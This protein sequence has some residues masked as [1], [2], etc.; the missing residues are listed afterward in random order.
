MPLAPATVDRLA[1]M[2]RAGATNRAVALALGISK[3][4][5]GRYR[6]ALGL[7]PAPVERRSPIPIEQKFRDRTRPVPGTP[8]L[9]WTGRTRDGVPVITHHGA[10]VTARPIAFRIRTGRAPVGYVTVECDYPGCV[11][12][13]CVEDEPGRIHHRAALAEI[14]GRRSTLTE[15]SRG[16]DTATHRRYDRTGR[17]YCGKCHTLAKQ[18]REAGQVAA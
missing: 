12:P 1:A 9:A 4:T 11:A 6:T 7:P 8:H 10:S 5:A 13:D 2:M 14:Q 3:D 18:A 17:A 16:H 15:C